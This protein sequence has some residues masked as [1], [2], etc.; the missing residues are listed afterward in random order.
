MAP[1]SR[2]PRSPP[3]PKPTVKQSP[4][5]ARST[6]ALALAD[7]YAGLESFG[8]PAAKAKRVIVAH[9]GLSSVELLRLELSERHQR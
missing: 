1:A 5:I 9:D 8:Q 2:Q 6:E 7:D 3:R 4:R